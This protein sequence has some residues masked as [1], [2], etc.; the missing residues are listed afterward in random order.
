MEKR[1]LAKTLLINVV[2][3]VLPTL[4]CFNINDGKLMF[5]N[6]DILNFMLVEIT[7]MM[8][9]NLNKFPFYEL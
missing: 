4:L 8:N 7:L 9:K 2:F 1:L 5:K 6:D 3:E